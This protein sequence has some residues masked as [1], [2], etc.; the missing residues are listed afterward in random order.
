MVQDVRL[1]DR[2]VSN[3]S[4]M[5]EDIRFKNLSVAGDSGM[6]EDV[7][8]RM[9]VEPDQDIGVAKAWVSPP[10]HPLYS[11]KHRFIFLAL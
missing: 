10:F 8:F 5:I 11:G 9:T 6:V 2:A 3:S 4:G 1:K 7:R